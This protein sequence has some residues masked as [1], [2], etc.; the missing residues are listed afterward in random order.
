MKSRAWFWVL[1]VFLILVLVVV[2]VLPKL[3]PH[4]FHGTLVQS[5]QVSPD[6][7]LTTQNA[8][9][10]SLSDYRGKLV[11]LYFGYTF[12]PDVCP[13]TLSEVNKAVNLLG[14]KAEDVQVVMVTVDPERDTPEKLGTYLEHFN[15][16][17][18]GMTGTQEEI[19]NAAAL[20]GVFFQ[21]HEGTEATGYLVDHT[22]SLM[23]LDEEGH[24]KLIF[25]F[26][27]SGNDIA[28]DLSYLL[29]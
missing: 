28:D 10:A 5:E 1:G 14:D 4:T 18:L 29:R 19:D 12:C 20:Y 15:P 26:G 8:Q 23:I 3:R 6:L 7:S 13:T 25:P 22:A 27:T 21:K 2:F 17:F 9:K 11:V 24:L 16:D